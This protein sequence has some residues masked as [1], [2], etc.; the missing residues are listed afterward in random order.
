MKRCWLHSVCYQRLWRLPFIRL[1][2]TIA[3]STMLSAIG[4]ALLP[5]WAP[6]TGLALSAGVI[7]FLIIRNQD[8]LVLET[9]MV[10]ALIR[11][12]AGCPRDVNV[13]DLSADVRAEALPTGVTRIEA[14]SW[15]D[16][17]RALGFVT[18]RDRGFQLDHLRRM[19]A[20]RLSEICGRFA[21]PIDTH[22]RSLRLAAVADL[23]IKSMEQEE[24]NLLEAFASGVTAAWDHDGPSFEC[25]F[26]RYRLEP[27][28]PS[29]SLLIALLLFY[30]LSWDEQSKRAEAVIR[31]VLPE[32]IAE[33]FLP[34]ADGGSALPEDLHQF[35]AHADR[36]SDIVSVNPVTAGSNCWIKSS[37]EGPVLAC[38]LHMPLGMPNLL[39]EVDLEYSGKRVR[40]LMAAGLPIVLTGSNG[41]IVWGVTNLHADTLDL[42]PA[43]AIDNEPTLLLTTTELINL[44]GGEQSSVKI[45]SV[46]RMLLSSKPLLGKEVMLRW[47]GYDPRTLDL[48]FQR[49]VQATTVDES[50]AILDQA[51]GLPLNVL[52]ADDLGRM[53]HLATGLL[54]RRKA[55]SSEIANEYLAGAERPRL[56][57]PP[58]GVLVSANDAALTGKPY[59]IG[60][61]VD[62][63]YR[64][65]RVRSML[66]SSAD[67]SPAAMRAMQHDTRAELYLSYRD[68]AVAAFSGQKNRIAAILAEWDGNAEVDSTAFAVL[69]RLRE[70][71]I[72]RVLVPYLSVCCDYEPNFRYGFQMIDLPVLA[73]I[74]SGDPSLLPPGLESAGWDGFIRRCV[75]TVVSDL[76]SRL[77]GLISW[78]D[79]NRVGLRHPL[80]DLAP[81]AGL[82]LGVTAKKQPGGHHCVRLCVPGFA[83][84]GRAVLRPG[85]FGLAEFETPGGQ[86]GHPLSSHYRDR[87]DAWAST[88]PRRNRR[89]QKGCSFVLRAKN[90]GELEAHSGGRTDVTTV[91]G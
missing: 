60:Y 1:I 15:L 40:G 66:A 50:I 14:Q 19:A 89:H 26:L 32:R 34:N 81:W 69:V 12:H 51:Q 17:V 3:I 67:T 4:A 74:R 30:G 53:A 77:P 79:I 25:Q 87:H 27:W 48:K 31:H 80:E 10:R 70:V 63:G 6:L 83:A 71:L 90:Q 23:A 33:F 88:T 38:D 76:K 75:D 22:Y 37:P 39:Y 42:V 54:P 18:G 16:A 41:H 44:R 43:D 84:V 72:Q 7:V 46:G 47:T 49:L 21:L 58:T 2:T 85:P 36:I 11:S 73:I 45:T 65:R 35:R 8:R 20:G 56:V 24:L 55:Q 28:T 13:P 9:H 91:V 61:D 5:I 82:L 57:D 78:G 52:I 86:S 68:L 29:D 62:P 59:R 64:A